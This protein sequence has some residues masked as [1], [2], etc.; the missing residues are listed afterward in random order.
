MDKDKLFIVVY[1]DV[2]HI[3]ES[4]IVAYIQSVTNIMKF[5]DSVVRLFIP[6]R[7]S[8]TRIECI[9]P[10]LLTE[11]QYKDVE[12]KINALEQIVEEKLKTL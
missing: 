11:E 6:T 5:D 8:E 9:N 4:D 10:V 7:D 1:V 3:A 2:R 12:E